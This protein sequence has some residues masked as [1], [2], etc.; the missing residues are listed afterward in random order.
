MQSSFLETKQI[1]VYPREPLH[2]HMIKNNEIADWKSE[3]DDDNIDK[4]CKS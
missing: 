4:T 2:F 3:L 1:K